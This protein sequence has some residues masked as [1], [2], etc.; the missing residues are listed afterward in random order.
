MSTD[1]GNSASSILHAL[2][3]CPRYSGE[4]LSGALFRFT[5][6][7]G[8]PCLRRAGAQVPPPPP[9]PCS[10]RHRRSR[11]RRAPRNGHVSR[12]QSS[13]TQTSERS[14]TVKRD[15]EG[16]TD[17]NSITSSYWLGAWSPIVV[18]GLAGKLMACSRSSSCRATS[19]ATMGVAASLKTVA[20]AHARNYRCRIDRSCC[21]AQRASTE[22][23]TGQP[24]RPERRRWLAERS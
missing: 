7:C 6:A 17:V 15:V 5:G 3:V 19:A 14:A 20:P 1:A 8:H 22:G 13:R 18:C 2:R 11:T 4:S 23:R 10:T 24:A 9:R 21:A 16:P 12:D